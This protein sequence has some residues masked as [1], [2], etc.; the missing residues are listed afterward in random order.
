MITEIENNKSTLD[1]LE[2]LRQALGEI[3]DNVDACT[4]ISL[5]ATRINRLQDT[6]N[7]KYNSKEAEKNL[8]L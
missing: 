8:G 4:V 2:R 5:A 1:A 6:L 3:S 7:G